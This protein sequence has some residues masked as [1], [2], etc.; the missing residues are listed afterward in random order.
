MQLELFCA[1][2]TVRTYEQRIASHVQRE[3]LARLLA[4]PRCTKRDH[5]RSATWLPMAADVAASHRGHQLFWCLVMP[6][7]WNPCS[8]L[9]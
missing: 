7:R 6:R 8:A 3:R 9:S 4:T 1:E 2:E 5:R